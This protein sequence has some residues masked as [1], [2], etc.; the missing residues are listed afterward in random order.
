VRRLL[1]AALAALVLVPGGSAGPRA[2]PAFKHVFVI[3]FEN[4]E[5]SSV[6]GSAR[7][8]DAL[9]SRYAQLAGYRGVTHPSLPNYLALVSGSTQG[10][11]WDCTDCTVSA[12]SLADTLEASKK[13]WKTYAEGLPAPGWTG[14]LHGRYAKR[15]DP[16]LYFNG[17]LATPARRNRVVP[18]AQ[19][20]R[21]LTRRKLPD[22]ALLVPDL[23]NSMHDCPVQTGDAWLARVTKVLLKTPQLKNSVIFVI[24]DEGSTNVGGGGETLALALGPTVR[25]GSKYLPVLNHYGLLRTIEDAWGLRWLGRSSGAEPITGIWK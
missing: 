19:L 7:T 5:R 21:D 12:P 2:V 18:F 22:F 8:F 4:K 15:H 24:F 16:F 13:T 17:V 9:A 23:C 14:P 10:I 3:V 20:W 1:L 11:T 25:P 6:L